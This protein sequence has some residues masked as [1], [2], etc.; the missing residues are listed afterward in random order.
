VF[1]QKKQPNWFFLLFF[2]KKRLFWVFE[3]KQDFVL[4][5]RKTEK[6]N[7]LNC[8]YSIMQYHYFQNYTKITCYTYYGILN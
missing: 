1:F 2:K 6:K 3:K 5:S 8:F 7:I 4:F